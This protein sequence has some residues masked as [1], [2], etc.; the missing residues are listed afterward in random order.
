MGQVPDAVGLRNSRSLIR[1]G[2]LHICGRIRLP[3]GGTTQTEVILIFLDNVTWPLV[4]EK[5]MRVF[6]LVRD[7]TPR[8]EEQMCGTR[9]RIR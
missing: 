7:A 4:H 5:R 8:P 9:F 1:Q 2:L 6:V 3:S